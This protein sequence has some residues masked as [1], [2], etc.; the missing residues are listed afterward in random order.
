MIR[1]MFF[2]RFHSGK[3]WI[4]TRY[5]DQPIVPFSVVV[6]WGFPRAASA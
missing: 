4:Y 3:E 5:S 2:S 6:A 1:F